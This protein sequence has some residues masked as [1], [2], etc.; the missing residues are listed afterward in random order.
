MKKAAAYAALDYM[1]EQG[2]IGIGTGST[3]NYFIDALASR[4]HLLEGTVASSQATAE[5][6]KAHG[7][8]VFDLNVVGQLPIY[9]D[10]ADE[11]DAYLRLIKGGGGALTREKIIA[12]AAEQFICIA[13]QS[14]QVDRLGDFPIA[15]E[16]I[17]IARSYVGRQL[18]KL[19]GIPKYR[20]GF[21]T[22]NGNIIIDV[23]QLDISDPL[24]MEYLLNNITG[25]VCHGLFAKRTADK[26]LLGTETGVHL[27]KPKI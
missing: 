1:P 4:K 2:M 5:R 11:V 12:T 10:G 24:K 22:D 8:P 19:A 16:V 20:E 14:K 7:I 25:I 9:V 21:I 27:I 15:I 26:L 18:V 6:L 17:P 23:Y 13:D 3:I